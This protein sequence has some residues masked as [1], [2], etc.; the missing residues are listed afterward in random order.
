MPSK[1]GP[2]RA[3]SCHLEGPLVNI[4]ATGVSVASHMQQ[5]PPITFLYCRLHS[6]IKGSA[7]K[8]WCLS[9]LPQPLPKRV[10]PSDVV[11]TLVHRIAVN[12]SLEV[13]QV[14]FAIRRPIKD[15]HICA[16][17]TSTPTQPQHQL[18]SNHEPNPNPK[19]KNL[20]PAVLYR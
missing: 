16:T 14:H 13:T 1:G 18:H 4:N 12:S 2:R 19:H 3:L 5:K 15:D 20:S 11:I 10:C 9:P 17:S 6:D 7:V 8:K